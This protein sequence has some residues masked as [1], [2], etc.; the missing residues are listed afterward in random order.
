M[1]AM[2]RPRA[3][4]FHIVVVAFIP[5]GV[6]HDG[7][8]SDLVESNLL[9]TVARCRR[10]R[11]DRCNGIRIGDGPFEGLHPTHGSASHGEET[12]NAE[13]IDKTLLQANHVADGN[14]RKTHGE[15]LARCW[16]DAVRTGCALTTAQY[17]GADDEVAIGIKRFAWPDHGGPPAGLAVLTMDAGGMGITGEGMQD[18]NGVAVVGVQFAIG[19]ISYETLVSVTPQSSAR[20]GNEVVCVSTSNTGSTLDT[21]AADMDC[22]LGRTLPCNHCNITLQKEGNSM[23]VRAV[24]AMGPLALT[25]WLSGAE[26]NT[27]QMMA[28]LKAYAGTW[29]V[30]R[31]NAAAGAKPE[32]LKNDCSAVGRYFACQQTING[33]VGGLLLMIPSSTAGRYFTQNV[34]PNGR[35]TGAGEL[36][37]GTANKWVFRSTWNQGAQV[38]RYRTTNTFTGRDK[39]HFEQEESTDGQHWK[40]T[41]SGDDVRVGH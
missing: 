4:R 8:A 28:T 17:V 5:V 35:A 32:Q 13:R 41:G 18:Q 39:I 14:D 24:F 10:Y 1:R 40:V 11:N 30:V 19:F 15:I 12:L 25:G 21:A 33:E 23:R 9:G 38:V 7:L 36:L 3:R 29:T 22:L 2:A 20:L 26:P 31:Q 37:I 27:A 34:T 16:I 6:V